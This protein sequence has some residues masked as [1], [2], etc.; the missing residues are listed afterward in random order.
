MAL[1]EGATM[2]NNDR[3][4]LCRILVLMLFV[5]VVSACSNSG[6]GSNN[7]N[8]TTNR[9]N[10]QVGTLVPLAST[11]DTLD[12]YGPESI[13]F[14]EIHWS[15]V[16]K[17][18]NSQATI[19]NP[20]S[21]E[22]TFKP[23]IVGEYVIKVV[24]KQDNVVLAE[25][26]VTI[27]AGVDDIFPQKPSDHILST[28]I[29][30]AC[31]SAD[32]WQVINVNHEQVI[33]TC[34]SCHDG[35]IA[36]G[37]SA[38]HIMSNDQCDVCHTTT[39]W[40]TPFT[41]PDHTALVGSCVSCHN[42]INASG[43]TA[44]HLSTTDVCDACHAPFPAAWVPVINVDHTQTLGTCISCHDGVIASGKTMNHIVT[45][46]DCGNCHS[47]TA[48]VPATSGGGTTDP[49]PPPTPDPT[50]TVDHNNLTG[51]C[52][53]CH[54]G[55]DATGKPATHSLTTDTCDACHSVTS[56]VPVIAVDHNETIGTCVSCHNGVTASGK[57]PNHLVTDQDCSACHVTTRWLPAL[58]TTDPVPAP[59][60]EKPAGHMPTTDLCSA[61]HLPDG[62][63]VGTVDHDQVIGTC[64][65]CHDGVIATGKSAT[66]VPSS[67]NCDE[68]HAVT[69]WVVPSQPV[70]PNLDHSTFIGAC[71][72]CH[73][74]FDASGKSA[75]HINTT[76]I[77]EA[78]H[79]VYPEQ[80]VPATQVDH[81]E[82]LGT[83]ESCHNNTIALGKGPT[84][85]Q[86]T[87]D[88]SVCHSTTAWLPS[89]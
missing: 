69:T 8:D 62:W 43:K 26:E 42:G 60:P 71:V 77:C 78:C 11:T 86:T 1:R 58:S 49:A 10:V 22:P 31:H 48:W 36:T 37:K 80:W 68:C 9:K 73:N 89:I 84:H 54:N 13:L 85:I 65:T 21:A 56:W 25:N 18:P 15:I 64:V 29:C 46:E 7:N 38:T 63:I 66:H 39:T 57:G 33:G 5:F 32:N 19:L 67:D 83:C 70:D 14:I 24:I 44:T 74:G 27:V 75:T 61:C 4:M 79:G 30:T 45:T 3:W 87:R 6:D 53:T 72:S 12:A 16:S 41:A 23:D 88:C 82:V 35:V 81:N 34:A 52:I 55:T 2:T 50:P 17:P 51:S 20:D 47:T 59:L 28:D 40:G 76:D